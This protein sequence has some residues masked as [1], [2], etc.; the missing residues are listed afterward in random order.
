MEEALKSNLEAPSANAP[1]Y[2]HL[3]LSYNLARLH[4]ANGD[5]IKAKEGYQVRIALIFT[6]LFFFW[7]SIVII[8]ILDMHLMICLPGL[9]PEAN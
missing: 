6:H 1:K 7:Q 5:Y 3:T 2:Q 8:Q 9:K 4:E